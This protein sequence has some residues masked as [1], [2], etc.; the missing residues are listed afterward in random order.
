[1]CLREKQKERQ[2]APVL[3]KRR[4]GGSTPPEGRKN[5]KNGILAEKRHFFKQRADGSS[6][7][8]D[9]GIPGRQLRAQNGIRQHPSAGRRQREGTAGSRDGGDRWHPAGLPAQ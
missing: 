5:E 4:R 1:M 3:W 9:G 2:I 8:D 6:T 7:L